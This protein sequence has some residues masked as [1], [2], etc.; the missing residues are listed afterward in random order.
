M[1][2]NSLPFYYDIFALRHPT[3][4]PR[5]M[6]RDIRSRPEG[7]NRDAA[8]QRF[9]RDRQIPT[10]TTAAPIEVQSAF[11]GL[12]I[13]RMADAL[14]GARY[15]GLTKSG[16]GVCEHVRFNHRVAQVGGRRLFI[17]PWMTIGK[18]D[19]AL[20]SQEARTVRLMHC[21]RS[22]ALTTALASGCEEPPGARSFAR[23][24][25]LIGEAAPGTL[26]IDVGAGVG[27]EVALCRMEGAS[28][29]FVAVEPSLSR[30]KH[31]TITAVTRRRCSPA[32]RP[33][34]R[35][36]AAPK[37]PERRTSD[38]SRMRGCRICPGQMSCRWSSSGPEGTSS[39]SSNTR[40]PS[41]SR[42]GRPSGPT[43]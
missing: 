29:R 41:C 42:P 7:M 13:Y 12:A 8:R 36:S 23:L 15:R 3:W 10:P 38:P 22:C 25:R 21:G 43:L 9:V 14:G 1:F 19:V 28:L 34:G 4:R 6:I 32:W 37:G 17:L 33:R 5:D 30:Y 35:R 2:A 26:A 18:Q 24:A 16:R 31:L 27:A 39:R 11:G 40:S 20:Y